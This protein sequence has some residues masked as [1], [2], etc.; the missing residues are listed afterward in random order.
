MKELVFRVLIEKVG[1]LDDEEEMEYYLREIEN[2]RET[3]Q[4]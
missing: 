4:L 2:C 1:K 3:L